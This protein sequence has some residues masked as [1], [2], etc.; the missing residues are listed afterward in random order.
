VAGLNITV[1]EIDVQTVGMEVTVMGDHL[2]VSA[3]VR[4]IEST[5]RWCTAS[6]SWRRGEVP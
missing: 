2:E 1:T 3:L 5:G 4:A 6:T